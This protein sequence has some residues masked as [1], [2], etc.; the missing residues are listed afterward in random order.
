MAT[1]PAPSHQDMP[2]PSD[3]ASAREDSPADESAA[4]PEEN[5]SSE[6]KQSRILIG[7]QR[8]EGTPV[9]GNSLERDWIPVVETT[10]PKSSEPLPAPPPA[11]PPAPATPVV[12]DHAEV[13]PPP[14][15]DAVPTGEAASPVLEEDLAVA[16]P[17]DGGEAPPIPA[18]RPNAGRVPVPNLRRELSD[19]LLREFEEA[20]GSVEMDAIL[21]GSD[22]GATQAAFEVES[23]HHGRVLAVSSEEV[24]V[25]IGGR[26][27]G[28]VPLRQFVDPPEV[29]TE[30]D[31]IVTGFNKE[32]GLYDLMIPNAASSV[33]N[34]DDLREGMVVETKVTGHNSGGLECEVNHIRGFIPVSQISLFRVEDLSQFVDE[35]F[36]CLVTEANRDRRNLV[37]SRRAILEREKEE[38]RQQLLESLQPG[39]IHEGVVRKLMDFGAF[40]DIGGVDGLI[41]VSQLDWGRVE[42]PSEILAEGQTVKVKIL[43][44]DPGGNRISLG[45][46]D[47]LENPWDSVES[48]YPVG[49]TVAGR[50]S[51]IMEFG[52]FVQLER[53][54]EGL[55]HISEIAHKRV[56]RV[57]DFVHEG[58]EVSCVI[59]SVDKGNQRIGLSIKDA[60]EPPP[61]KESEGEEKEEDY[62][63]TS[64][65]VYPTIELKGGIERRGDDGDRFGLKW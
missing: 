12:Q 65:K 39:Q 18:P 6:P 22:S 44:V 29:G 4:P 33:E 16:E 20:M 34:W 1:D 63:D 61:K 64:K 21:E 42:H 25:D 13:E 30:L 45:Y 37:L 11:P 53:G 2:P 57:S 32:D 17:A 47:M 23:Q 41:H 51:K 36:T 35:R 7:S 31:V 43:K 40:V 19:D 15:A 46:R 28:T 60:L 49:M 3:T 54:V 10:E 27:Q 58:D 8:P 62:S 5:A 48:K 50:V 56:F 14:Q 55:V 9:H 52:A 38:A 59:K 26:E 24:F